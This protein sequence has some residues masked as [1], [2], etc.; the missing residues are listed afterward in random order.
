MLKVYCVDRACR[1]TVSKTVAVVFTDKLGLSVNYIYGSF[2]AGCRTQTTAGT[3]F[4]VNLNYLSNHS[5][6]LIDFIFSLSLFID[7]TTI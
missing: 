5:F 3:F 7:F 4:L 2:M 6:L 1:E